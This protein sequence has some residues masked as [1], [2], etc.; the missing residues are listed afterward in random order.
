M[1]VSPG[2]TFPV[3]Q[4]FLEDILDKTNYVIEE[5][6]SSARKMKKSGN[7]GPGDITSLECELEVADIQGSANIIKNPATRDENL[8]I[9]Q[10]FYRYKGKLNDVMW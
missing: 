10:L 8:T 6:S 3:E 7:S 4:L 2:R 1:V 9:T 5:N